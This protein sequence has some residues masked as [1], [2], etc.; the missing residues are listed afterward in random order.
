METDPIREGECGT[1]A[2]VKLISVGRSPAVTFSPPPTLTCDM[3]ATLAGWL[4]DDVQ[5]LARTHLGSEIVK[6]ETMSSYSCRNAYGRK[7]TRLSE[8]ARANAVDVKGFFTAAALETGPL[9]DWGMTER[10]ILAAVAA[11]AA[12]EKTAAAERAKAA[13]IAK[14]EGGTSDHAAVSTGT[15]ASPTA[16]PPT[17]ARIGLFGARL[18]TIVEGLPATVQGSATQSGSRVTSFTF[19]EPSRLGGPKPQASAT[20]E[21]YPTDLGTRKT[22]FL[23]AVHDAAC[24]RFGTVLGPEANEYHRN[25]FHLDMAERTIRNICE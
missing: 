12:A 9:A 23:R 6:I 16:A 2:P 10:E 3:V 15:T 5:P 25:H 24:G 4:K 8:H 22:L 20:A 21:P 18:G 14:A 7:K 17:F 19:A 1:P 13:V 11:Q